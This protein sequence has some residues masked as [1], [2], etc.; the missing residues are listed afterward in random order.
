MALVFTTGVLTWAYASMKITR[1]ELHDNLRFAMTPHGWDVDRVRYYIRT[2][3][4]NPAVADR[5]GTTP[6]MVA[7]ESGDPEF[8]R[9]LLQRG[10]DVNAAEHGGRTALHYAPTLPDCSEAIR[11][12]RYLVSWAEFRV[13]RAAVARDQE[14]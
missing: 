2:C 9:Y 4:A 3:R 11:I 10:L 7:A 5:S 12:V 13:F 1:G 14:R 8:V 6:L